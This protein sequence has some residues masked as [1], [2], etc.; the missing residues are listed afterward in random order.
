MDPALAAETRRRQS[1]DTTHSMPGELP[2]DTKLPAGYIRYVRVIS[3]L[4]DTSQVSLPPP[5]KRSAYGRVIDFLRKR[6]SQRIACS[7]TIGYNKPQTIHCQTCIRR[8]PTSD[9]LRSRS[10]TP[11]QYRALSYAWGD[12]TPQYQILVDGHPRMIAE[13]LWRFLKRRNPP[14][15]RGQWLWIDALSIDQSD[16]EERRHQVG[17]MSMIFRN[18][19]EVVVWLGQEECACVSGTDHALDL[20]DEL[21][22]RWVPRLERRD[23][24]LSKIESEALID[25]CEL[26]YWQ[27]LWVFQEIRYART[28]ILLHGTALKRWTDF[29]TLFDGTVQIY[30][31]FPPET[32]LRIN[33]SPAAHMVRLHRK[34]MDTSL[35]NLLQESKHMACT[36]RLDKVYAILSIAT[37][38]R[39]DIEADYLAS[40]ESLGSRVLRNHYD[41]NPPEARSIVLGHCVALGKIFDIDPMSIYHEIG[42]FQVCKTVKYKLADGTPLWHKWPWQARDWL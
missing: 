11:F 5:S 1:C 39:G 16:T 22:R 19:C 13:N 42:N 30:D 23:R 32:A 9:E 24:P 28:I 38:G 27:R 29:V 12:R 36:D 8:S 26:P 21:P 40:L 2:P 41:T 3:V 4:V 7:N 18:A 35:W 14:W 15:P 33:S 17:I 10:H 34:L 20:V 31:A 37:E 25:L 6:G